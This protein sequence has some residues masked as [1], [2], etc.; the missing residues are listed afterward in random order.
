LGTYR[1]ARQ[2]YLK[3]YRYNPDNAALN[4][5]IGLCYLFTD[6]KFEAIKYLNKAANLNP[7][8]APDIKY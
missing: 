3:A 6:E 4:Y 5:N 1:E 2:N 7:D 8:I